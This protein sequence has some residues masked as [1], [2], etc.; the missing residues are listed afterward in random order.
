MKR[1]VW[2]DDEMQ[3]VVPIEPTD[4][5]EVA[6]ENHYESTGATFPDWKGEYRAMLAAAPTVEEAQPV[7]EVRA[8]F[9]AWA[10]QEYKLPPHGLTRLSGGE[11]KYSGVSDAWA[12][13]CAALSTRGEQG[14]WS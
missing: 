5:M 9:E 3:R 10:K 4:E 14:V 13:W 2:I 11:Y 8:A 7:T 1:L 6:A 12:G